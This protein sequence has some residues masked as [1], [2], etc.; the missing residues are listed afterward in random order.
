MALRLVV[1]LVDRLV[2]LKA[3]KMADV[4]AK[5]HCVVPGK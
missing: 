2:V 1:S 4:M 5:S 3:A